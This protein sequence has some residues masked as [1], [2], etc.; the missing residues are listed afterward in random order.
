[1]LLAA[2]VETTNPVE[3]GVV[4]AGAVEAGAVELLWAG[5]AEARWARTTRGTA[6]SIVAVLSTRGLYKGGVEDVG[7][8][9]DREKE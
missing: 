2:V 6:D 5:M 1:M 8:M 3:T 9:W 4:E 7:R